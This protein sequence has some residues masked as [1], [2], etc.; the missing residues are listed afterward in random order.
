MIHKIFL[1]YSLMRLFF[2]LV[3]L[4]FLTKT[5]FSKDIDDIFF[6]GKMESYNKSFTLYFKT[7]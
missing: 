2:V 4:L 6:I 3:L 5:S 1:N 7:R